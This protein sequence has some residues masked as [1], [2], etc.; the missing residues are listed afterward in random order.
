MDC[1]LIATLESATLST[2]SLCLSN[3]TNI[4]AKCSFNIMYYILTRNEY[5][6]QAES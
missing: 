1:G 3:I 6:I 5:K 4:T 2:A